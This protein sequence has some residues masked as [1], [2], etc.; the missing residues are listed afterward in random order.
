MNGS[1]GFPG[2]GNGQN[3]DDWITVSHYFYDSSEPIGE[4]TY[5]KVYL[6]YDEANECN[7]VALKVIRFYDQDEK[8][9]E[10]EIEVLQDIKC[11]YVIRFIE[12]FISGDF[13]YIVMEYCDGGSL[14][15]AIDEGKLFTEEEACILV[16]EICIAFLSLKQVM[17]RDIKP[18]NILFHQ[19]M[20]KIA[21][22]GFAKI[23]NIFEKNTLKEHT[24]K[25]GTPYYMSP[26]IL[27]NDNYSV[28]CD[29]WST[30]CVLYE[31]LFGR[32]PWKADTPSNL[33]KAITTES[34]NFPVD[35]KI[36]PEL[37]D[38]IKRMLTINDSERISWSEIYNH[39]ALEYVS[40]RGD[41]LDE[42]LLNNS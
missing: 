30:G 13:L 10:R 36:S 21:D 12:C 4:G 8:A 19:E 23:V 18:D 3:G 28:K 33:Y 27:H 40:P 7:K 2:G 25:V 15:K 24:K 35:K 29:V 31:C 16:K 38:L 34:L 26:Q 5:G 41:E 32:I 6:A 9:L 39:A 37:Q 1:Q 14:Q 20:T 11:S 17:H 22:F 42:S